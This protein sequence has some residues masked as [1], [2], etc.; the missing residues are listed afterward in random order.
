MKKQHGSDLFLIFL[1][2]FLV[3]ILCI[4]WTYVSAIILALLI[5]GVLYPVYFRVKNLFKGRE[6]LASLIMSLLIL[7]VLVIPVGW[8]VGTL[9]NEAL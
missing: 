8:F 5:S 1:F 4:F 2:C 7:L 3:L 9:S 6:G